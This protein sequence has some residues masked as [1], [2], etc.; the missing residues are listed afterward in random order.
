M[1]YAACRDK[2]M[3]CDFLKVE[4]TVIEFLVNY[5]S[6]CVILLVCAFIT[7]AC[8]RHILAF[9]VTILLPSLS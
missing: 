2:Y 8:R 6:V 4:A 3:S 5:F 9:I 1:I 7:L